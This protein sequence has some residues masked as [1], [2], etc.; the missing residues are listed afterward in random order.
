MRVKVDV[1]FDEEKRIDLDFLKSRE[2]WLPFTDIYIEFILK[3]IYDEFIDFSID[4]RDGGSKVVRQSWNRFF[5]NLKETD[6]VD[7]K[8]F[9][10]GKLLVEEALLFN[11]ID[12]KVPLM[13]SVP[14][15]LSYSISDIRFFSNRLSERLINNTYFNLFS[16]EVL[17]KIQETGYKFSDKA[18]RKWL[19][20]VFSILTERGLTVYL[21]P[22]DS[23]IKYSPEFKNQLKDFLMDFVDWGRRFRIV[24]D[25]SVNLTGKEK[26]SYIDS[27]HSKFD[28]AL[29]VVPEECVDRVGGEGVSYLIQEFA[30]GEAIPENDKGI[31][32]ARLGEK[33]KV[34]FLGLR[35][36]VAKAVR[37]GWGACY[38]YQL[39]RKGLKS[40]NYSLAEAL[41]RG[42]RDATT[43]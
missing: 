5:V 6:V 37:S 42:Y 35:K 29:M 38:C 22:F 26:M 34:S 1:L 18:F 13:F 31:K 2:Y 20:L 14:S 41:Y 3:G 32:I 8:V 16:L 11:V 27:I 33:E 23:D 36:F 39:Y 19:N 43:E 30:P 25:F 15:L 9:M 24:W 21:S 12:L 4:S 28:D 40:I 17:E 10:G 7:F